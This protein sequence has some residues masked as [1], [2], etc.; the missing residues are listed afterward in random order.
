MESVQIGNGDYV[1]VPKPVNLKPL[2]E[3]AKSDKGNKWTDITVAESLERIMQGQV[4]VKWADIRQ[5]FMD[6]NDIKKA[7]ADDIRTKISDDKFKPT[8]IKVGGK[9]IDYWSEKKH[10]TASVYI[11][12]NEVTDDK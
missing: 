3:A 10:Q 6:D 7:R 5:E 11:H 2:F 1:G 9:N 4:K 8:R 12:R